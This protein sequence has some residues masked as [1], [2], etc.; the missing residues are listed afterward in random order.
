MQRSGIVTDPAIAAA[1]DSVPREIFVPGA[2]DEVYVDNAL[3]TYRQQGVVV[4]TSSQPTMMAIM[5]AQLAVKPGMRIL[6]IGTGSGYNAAILSRLVGTAGSVASVEFDPDLV[7][8][9]GANLSEA[10]ATNVTVFSGDGG[11][12][13]PPG[14]PYDRIIATAACWQVPPPWLEQLTA[15]GLLVLPFR[16]NTA[17]VCLALQRDGALLTA[18]EPS[19][20][21]FMHL[22]GDYG[23]SYELELKDGSRL[24]VDCPLHQ[25]RDIP[26]LLSAYRSP[27]TL[28]R[29]IRHR[30]KEPFYFLA[31]Q[32]APFA[33]WYAASASTLGQLLLLPGSAVRFPSPERESAQ[34]WGSDAAFDFVA[35]A[36][37][38]WH[39]A[40]APGLA[41][42]TFTA[43]PARSDLP[44]LP[45]PDGNEYRF[46]RGEHEYR[47]SFGG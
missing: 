18:R 43:R 42:T 33:L 26:D 5:C 1:F 7:A 29:P 41:Q 22:R 21:M 9:A 38:R 2:L 4:S 3:A 15:D 11:A 31:L 16:L 27:G 17:Q 34:L 25:L 37:Q 46:R 8:R 36:L 6:E 13:H 19:S 24:E 45:T 28:P 30:W 23:P 12:G 35:A 39:Q 47:V 44:V 40:S 14:A 20:C 10:G 32:G